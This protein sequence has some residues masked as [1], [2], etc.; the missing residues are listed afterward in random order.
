MKAPKYLFIGGKG[1]VGK[2]T[3]ASATAL[4]SARD[5]KKTLL[6][7]T[8]PAH[9]LSDIFS[10]KPSEKEVFVQEHLAIVE[11]D[12]K[13]EVHQYVNQVATLI[14]QFIASASYD[15][16]DSYY[17]NVKRSGIA[18]E[19][20]LF[21]RLVGILTCEDWDRI[22]VD[23]APTGHTLRL[24]AMP[25]ILKEWSKTLLAQQEKSKY[26]EGIIGHIEG[27]SPLQEKLEERH[28]RYSKFFHL[29]HQESGI[30]FVLNPEY[31]PIIETSRAIKELK[32][33]SLS[34][35]ALV[36]NKIPPKSADS[37]FSQRFE[38]SEQYMQQIKELFKE[39]PLC[40][41]ALQSQDILGI[42]ALQNIAYSLLDLFKTHSAN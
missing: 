5:K 19:S 24:F 35:M 13:K 34:P 33:E 6:I 18:Q 16:L 9:N 22:V 4:L 39:Y 21:D 20:A 40:N 36:I 29:L 1:G 27:K 28:L 14:K 42:E 12:P 37:F 17:N 2:S 32:K 38:T 7:S 8:D 11:I 3:I 41:I 30:I 10:F 15:M 25:K 26:M 23:T 31:L